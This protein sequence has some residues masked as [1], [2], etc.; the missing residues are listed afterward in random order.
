M[1]IRSQ[2]K[3]ELTNINLTEKIYIKTLNSY[4]PT[5]YAVSVIINNE[6]SH[7]LGVYY[8]KERALEVLD[9][10]QNAIIYDETIG[11]KPIYE[12]PKE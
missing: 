4:S 2:D 11:V 6:V 1:W 10:I 5:K 8:T 7:Y 12:M 3:E 9:D